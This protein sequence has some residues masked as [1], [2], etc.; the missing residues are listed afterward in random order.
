ML[1]AQVVYSIGLLFAY[2]LFYQAYFVI[3]AMCPWCM[4][5]TVTTT[6]VFA[7]MTR[8]NILEGNFGAPVR[9]RLARPLRLGLDAAGVVVILGIL[10]A[11]VLYKYT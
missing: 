3:G 5:I 4:L 9:N 8:V 2:W 6:L 10:A 11:M 7:S 1:S